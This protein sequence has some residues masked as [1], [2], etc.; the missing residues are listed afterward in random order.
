MRHGRRRVRPI[1]RPLTARCARSLSHSL[2]HSLLSSAQIRALYG[3]DDEIVLIFEYGRAGD[4]RLVLRQD[5]ELQAACITWPGGPK[6]RFVVELR[7]FVDVDFDRLCLRRLQLLGEPRRLARLDKRITDKFEAAGSSFIM[8]L[9]AV[10]EMTQEFSIFHALALIMKMRQVTFPL[11]L[12]AGGNMIKAEGEKTFVSFADPAG[13]VL[14]GLMVQNALADYNDGVADASMRMEVSIGIDT[15]RLLLIPHDYYGDCVNVSSKLAEDTAEPGQL[16]VTKETH[17]L[18]RSDRRLLAAIFTANTATRS[19]VQL[20]YFEVTGRLQPGVLEAVLAAAPPVSPHGVH[21]EGTFA[22]LCRQRLLQDRAGN[23]SFVDDRIRERYEQKKVIMC[24]DMSGFTRTVKKY[25]IL[26]FLSIIMKMRSICVPILVD[27][28]GQLVK[29]EAD[30]LYFLFDDPDLAV[31]GVL[32]AQ[33][34]LRKWNAAMDAE[35]RA[36]MH[37][38]MDFGEV[39]NATDDHDIY[40]YHRNRAEEL[41]EG[42]ADDEEILI[43]ESMAN[44]LK[45]RYQLTEVRETDE[46]KLPYVQV[47]REL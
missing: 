4:K 27:H 42:Q 24:S 43:T 11:I 12:A 20:N 5:D 9:G 30:N 21:G 23:T 28:G 46:G 13:A 45:G 34:A 26:H 31:R 14:A 37:L 22:K 17:D 8:K 33:A 35:S 6:T 7:G 1:G 3:E 39:L 44:M 40:G 25:G 16:L 36:I 41:G 29:F 18:V 2:T 19:G 32:K 38:G 15:G 47:L 10:G